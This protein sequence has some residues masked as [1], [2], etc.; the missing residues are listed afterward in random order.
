MIVSGS[1]HN[2]THLHG[3]ELVARVYKWWDAMITGITLHFYETKEHNN[4]WCHGKWDTLPMLL[5]QN[6]SSFPTL[7]CHAIDVFCLFLLAFCLQGNLWCTP[8]WFLGL[9]QINRLLC[10]NTSWVIP[11]IHVR[12]LQDWLALFCEMF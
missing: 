10:L 4:N 1:S 6:V 2:V 5:L 9:W 11:P 12:L 3:I 7:W 8:L